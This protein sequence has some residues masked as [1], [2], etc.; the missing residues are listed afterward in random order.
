M[1]GIQRQIGNTQNIKKLGSQSAKSLK[2]EN[3]G[4]QGHRKWK[5]N[6]QSEGRQMK[7]C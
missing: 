6:G 1:R 7:Q 3:D 4:Q 5:P 2:G